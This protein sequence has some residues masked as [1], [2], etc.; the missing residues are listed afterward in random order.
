MAF[1]PQRDIF[2][3]IDRIIPFY[4]KLIDGLKFDGTDCSEIC[5]WILESL[6]CA[7]KTQNNYKY[8]I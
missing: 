3:G 7:Y 2:G 1:Q 5:D 4:K 8:F 6:P